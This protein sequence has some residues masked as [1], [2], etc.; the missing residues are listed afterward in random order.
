MEWYPVSLS[1]LSQFTWV[2]LPLED[3]FRSKGKRVPCTLGS[4]E[5]GTPYIGSYTFR[6]RLVSDNRRHR[7][8]HAYNTGLKYR[9]RLVDR[10]G[11]YL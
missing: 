3:V 1:I 10:D 8:T 2:R 6:Q 4:A 5:R 9:V 7:V 11:E